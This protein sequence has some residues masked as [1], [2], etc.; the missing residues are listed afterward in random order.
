MKGKKVIHWGVVGENG[1]TI[2]ILSWKCNFNIYL[3]IQVYYLDIQAITTLL[4][5]IGSL[6]V[7]SF[8]TFKLSML[9]LL[10]WKVTSSGTQKPK[11]PRVLDL[12]EW[13]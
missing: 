9:Q 11:A 12:Q 13:D 8:Y 4:C 7:A 5:Y 1:G 2:Q 10:S 3:D 6:C